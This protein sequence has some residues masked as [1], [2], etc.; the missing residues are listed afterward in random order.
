MY[1]LYFANCFLDFHKC[2]HILHIMEITTTHVFILIFIL[3]SLM[4]AVFYMYFM[5]KIKKSELYIIDIF[6]QKISKIPAVIEV[7]R[8]YVIDTHTAFDLMIQ[9]HS[10][11]IIQDYSSIHSLLEHN[12]RINDQYAFL[13]KLS[14]AIPEL[15]KNTYFIYIRDYVISYERMMKKEL[16]I[17]N[18]NVK[19]WNLFIR[20][21]NFTII[22]YMYPWQE[23]VEI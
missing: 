4:Y 23:M 16:P 8:P 5:Q 7:I 1:L 22:G 9:L 2:I 11:S 20:M 19:K 10:E 18:K 3:L 21:K 13:M 15:Q 12:A 14:M 6:L 17:F